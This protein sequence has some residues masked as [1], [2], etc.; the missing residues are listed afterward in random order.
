[1]M[2]LL[3][4]VLGA[5]LTTLVLALGPAQ[6]MRARAAE[7]VTT[8]QNRDVAVVT[9]SARIYFGNLDGQITL[10]QERVERAPHVALAQRSLGGL[11]YI[12]AKHRGDLTEHAQALAHV[13][14]A[15]RL[16]PSDPANYLA[17]AEQ[18]QTVHRFAAARSDLASARAHGALASDVD[19][20]E[21]ELD[22]VD[23][24]YEKAIPAIRRAAAERRTMGSIARLA[25]LEHDLGNIEAA[26]LAFREAMSLVRDPNPIPV[27][28]LEVQMG[29]HYRDVGQAERAV[30]CFR[31]ALLRIPG[32]VAAEDHLA[33]T[34]HELG[35]D[36]EAMSIYEGIVSHS[37]DPEFKGALA[38]IYRARG[39]VAEADRLVAEATTTY[40]RLLEQFPE[41]MYWHA[42][43]FFL[44]EGRNPA[45][46][47]GLLQKNL[48]L[49]AG[50]PSYVALARAH[51]ATGNPALAKASIDRAL[52]MPI[53]SPA[54][55]R[56]AAE[57]DTAL[58]GAPAVI[59]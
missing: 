35:R 42:A 19:A 36:D 47:L 51:L 45:R 16:D 39:R 53:V 17:R 24:N 50:A 25:L 57:V 23:G 34:L 28:W 7:S 26:E 27:A 10:A 3:G 29:I 1:M 40:D 32:Y 20:L 59:R 41:A 11:L 55:T 12:R 54:T 44:E 9:T 6:P 21:R 48:V 56:T 37:A 52:A 2:R 33:E 38:G 49:R 14:E 8:P 4:C 15:V 43:E 46:A 18:L 5:A 22:Y 30:E 58:G 13:S 31:K